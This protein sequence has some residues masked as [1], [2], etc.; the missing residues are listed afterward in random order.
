MGRESEKEQRP[1][2]SRKSNGKGMF[3]DD[4][5][6]AEAAASQKLQAIDTSTLT[7]MTADDPNRNA[8]FASLFQS[9]VNTAAVRVMRKLGWKPGAA[10]AP[11]ASA[12]EMREYFMAASWS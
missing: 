5:D 8:P 10:E 12:R 9:A 4:E 11:S 7:G 2:E 6:R 1:D 3:E